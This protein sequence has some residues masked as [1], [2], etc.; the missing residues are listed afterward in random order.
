MVLKQQPNQQMAN[1][2]L[3]GEK[4]SG[5]LEKVRP[6]GDVGTYNPVTEEFGVITKD[7]KIRTYYRP[8]P[9]IHGKQNNLEYFNEQ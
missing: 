4:P 6:N 2:F 7:G 8:N 1:K 9:A 3:T 5:I